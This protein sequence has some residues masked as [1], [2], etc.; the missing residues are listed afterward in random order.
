MAIEL[1]GFAFSADA[2]ADLGTKQFHLV[3]IVGD[4]KI[5]VCD[6]LGDTPCGILQNQPKQGGAAE[7]V[8]YGISKAVVGE[9]PVTAGMKVTTD[10]EGTI[11][12]ASEG[13]FTIGQVLIGAG[14]GEVASVL[15]DCAVPVE[16]AQVEVIE[17]GN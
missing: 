14:A 7:V 13:D 5:D 12:E 8:T 6:A 11:V 1:K 4:Y 2:N 9:A 16:V 17:G 15:I 10:T 3:K